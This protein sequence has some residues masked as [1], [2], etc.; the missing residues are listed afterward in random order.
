MKPRAATFL[1]T[2]LL[3]SC[4]P[5]WKFKKDKALFEASKVEMRFTSVADM[6]D[7]YFIIKENNF[8]E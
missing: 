3:A 4:S 1:I 8:F 6:N 7:S 5:E 2:V